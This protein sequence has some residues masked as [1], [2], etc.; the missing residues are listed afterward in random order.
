MDFY[1]ECDTCSNIYTIKSIENAFAT[2]INFL[3][4]AEIDIYVGALSTN[5]FRTNTVIYIGIFS[6]L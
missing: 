2:Y 1:G 5:L 6:P 3:N 4:V